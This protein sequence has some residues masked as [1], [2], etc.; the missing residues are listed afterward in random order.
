M[1]P[2]A[3]EMENEVPVQQIPILHMPVNTELNHIDWPAVKV[4]EAG[5]TEIDA[6]VAAGAFIEATRSAHV[7]KISSRYL[8]GAN[9]SERL[10]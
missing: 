6:P 9:F 10:K 2:T 7:I 8:V 1:V 5:V 4:A 3:G